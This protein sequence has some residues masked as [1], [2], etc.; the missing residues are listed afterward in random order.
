VLPS[1][2]IEVAAFWAGF[3]VLVHDL[4]PRSRQL[5][6]ECERLQAQLDAWHRTQP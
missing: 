5:L 4:A 2:G 3:A 1:A 6:A